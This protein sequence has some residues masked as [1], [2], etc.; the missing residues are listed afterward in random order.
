LKASGHRLFFLSNMPQPFAEHLERSHAVLTV[1]ESGL[2]S[3]RVKLAKPDPR[4]F[5]LAF[6]QFEIEAADSLFVDDHV[7]NVEAAEAI[8]LPSH[9]FKTAAELE[10]V[11][12]FRGLLQP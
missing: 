12:R 5:E 9:R 10:E 8:G 6:S 3:S 2:F 11:L 1:F 7:P 4:I